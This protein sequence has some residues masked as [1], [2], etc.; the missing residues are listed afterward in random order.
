[1]PSSPSSRQP[2][3]GRLP[4][5]FRRLL[6]AE[7]SSGELI[8]GANA[9]LILAAIVSELGIDYRPHDLSR[10]ALRSRRGELAVQVAEVLQAM[11]ISRVEVRGLRVAEL[12][13]AE[14]LTAVQATK[15]WRL[16]P[17]PGFWTAEVPLFLTRQ[18]EVGPVG[19]NVHEVP[20]HAWSLLRMLRELQILN[21]FGML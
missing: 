7:R 1:M 2:D 6:W 11:A 21:G 20:P 10:E 9:D 18:M 3:R 13:T 16:R 8:A 12:L 4:A 17:R 5:G 14:E 15:R 19:G